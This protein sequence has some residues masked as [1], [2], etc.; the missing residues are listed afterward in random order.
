M[1]SRALLTFVRFYTTN[2]AHPHLYSLL[3]S[4]PKEKPHIPLA[5]R[6]RRKIKEK[7]TKYSP[8]KVALQVLGS[9]AN[10]APNSLYVFSDQSR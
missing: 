4:M 10:G 1:S 9:G 7:F 5:Q 3:K 2:S 6:Q 8:G